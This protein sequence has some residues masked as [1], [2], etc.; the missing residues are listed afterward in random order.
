M[1]FSI[2]FSMRVRMSWSIGGKRNVFLKLKSKLGNWDFLML[3][4]QLEN[5]LPKN[6]H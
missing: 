5:L 3:Y 6:L 1:L 2:F 4:L